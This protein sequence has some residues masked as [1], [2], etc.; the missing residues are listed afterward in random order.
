M[1]NTL[2]NFAAIQ[3]ALPALAARLLENSGFMTIEDIMILGS[4]DTLKFSKVLIRCGG[5]RYLM[6]VQASLSFCKL[7]EQNN[8][9]YV[10]DISIPVRA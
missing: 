5:G 9:D 7:I 8:H 3:T 1:T 2:C 4:H 6:E 10:R